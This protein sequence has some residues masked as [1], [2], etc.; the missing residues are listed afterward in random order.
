MHAEFKELQPFVHEFKLV[1]MPFTLNDILAEVQASN[2]CTWKSLNNTRYKDWRPFGP[3]STSIQTFFSSAE[4]QE[5]LIGVMDQ[6]PEFHNDYW[7]EL[8]NFKTGT[9]GYM[10][11]E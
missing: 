9:E 6:R 3:I 11:P 8:H 10:L 7:H 4:F 1:N 5:Q 2:W